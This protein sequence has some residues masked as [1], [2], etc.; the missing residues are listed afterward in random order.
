M[1]PKPHQPSSQGPSGRPKLSP[2]DLDTVPD[3]V[4]KP[5]L[6]SLRTAGEMAVDVDEH[7][8][9]ATMILGARL[10]ESLIPGPNGA[11]LDPRTA[12]FLQALASICVR[13]PKSDVYAVAL[14]VT[15]N[16]TTLYISTNGDVPEGVE[17]YLIKVFELMSRI[18]GHTKSR[19]MKPDSTSPERPIKEE[20]QALEVELFSL[21]Y[22][23]TL[24]KFASR[25]SKHK[26]TIEKFQK[27]RQNIHPTPSRS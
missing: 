19:R 13:E 2:E 5:S 21:V 7:V 20:V 18:S 12:E 6:F 25:F 23:H 27:S 9:Y 16:Q 11:T 3:R 4:V 1:R 26:A 15:A 8:A 22:K 24:K 17:N 10:S 14:G